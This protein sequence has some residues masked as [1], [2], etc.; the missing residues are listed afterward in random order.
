MKNP[1]IKKPMPRGTGELSGINLAQSKPHTDL[2]SVVGA[3]GTV[4]EQVIGQSDIKLSVQTAQTTDNDPATAAP[5][6][7]LVN[8]KQ[9]A[10]ISAET[11]ETVLI[12]AGALKQDTHPRSH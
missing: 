9:G 1:V 5:Q 6:T 7:I 3:Y 12:G 8:A 2:G 4:S 10:A 11:G